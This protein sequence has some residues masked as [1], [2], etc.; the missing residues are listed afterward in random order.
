MALGVN[1]L[2]TGLMQ[3]GVAMQS[4]LLQNLGAQLR[5]DVQT[6][7]TNRHDEEWRAVVGHEDR[8]LVSNHGRVMSLRYG[9]TGKPRLMRTGR[10]N[11][12]RSVDL[13]KG[14]AHKQVNVHVLV[15][16]AFI[17]PRQNGMEVNHKDG[18]KFN[19]HIS[20]LEYVTSSE[21]KLHAHRTGL[22]IS[23]KGEKSGRSKL[24]PYEVET[25]LL[26]VKSGLYHKEIAPMFGV[27]KSNIS[28]IVCG[29]SWS[30]LKS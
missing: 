9:R 29:K 21:N 18:V 30:C 26:L 3:Q 12:Y 19:N 15:A 23:L 24:K 28:A 17:G 14:G 1:P 16:E 6:I 25:I 27:T 13:F 5:S 20:N 8:Y 22:K 11:W 2:D 4:Q 7:Q 10:S